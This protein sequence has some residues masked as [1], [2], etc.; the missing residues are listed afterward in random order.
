MCGRRRDGVAVSTQPTLY[1]ALIA[2]NIPID[3]H[4]SDLYFPNVEAAR[5][6]LRQYPEQ[7]KLGRTFIPVYDTTITWI[8]VPFA[9]D[10]YWEGIKVHP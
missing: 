4:E 5:V 6:I 3:H 8:E 7:H 1:E 9:Y 10:P 2:A